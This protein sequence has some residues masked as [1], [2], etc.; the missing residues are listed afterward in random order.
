[1]PWRRGGEGRLGPLAAP[2]CRTGTMTRYRWEKTVRAFR[3]YRSTNV[4]S[5]APCTGPRRCPQGEQ[6][7][8]GF[9]WVGSE[10]SHARIASGDCQVKPTWVV[11]CTCLML[12]RENARFFCQAP[13]RRARHVRA[14]RGG[15]QSSAS[16]RGN[17]HEER[18]RRLGGTPGRPAPVDRSVPTTRRPSAPHDVSTLFRT[19][20]PYRRFANSAHAAAAIAN[21]HASRGRRC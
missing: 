11:G 19:P 4:R 10:D 20:N 17:A 15:G 14:P 13:A 18:L 1:M 6:Q 16:R 21:A 5:L 7:N 12:S 3:E 9:F 2:S 8:S